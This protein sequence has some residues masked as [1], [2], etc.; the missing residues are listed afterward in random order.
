MALPTG[1]NSFVLTFGV[2]GV[3][4]ADENLG[5]RV[6]VKAATNAIWGSTGQPYLNKEQT[7]TAAVGQTGSITLIN[8]DQDGFVDGNGNGLRNWTY[9]IHVDYI[10][11]TGKVVSSSNKNLAYMTAMGSPIDLDLTIPVST[12]AG[13]I[14]DIPDGSFAL[15]AGGVDGQ[16]LGLVNGQLGWI[17]LGTGSGSNTLTATGQPNITGTAQPGN[18]LTATTGSWSPAPTSYGYQWKR[19]GNTILGATT[20]TYTVATADIG[21][22]LTVTV[23]ATRT[24]YT[25]G[26]ATSAPTTVTAVGTGGGS[27][28]GSPIVTETGDSLTTESGDL[29][30][31]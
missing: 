10:D 3:L 25:T 21:Q 2:A 29:L 6:T 1:M 15:P 27:T 9:A 20:A 19:A 17:T 16:V 23:V 24:G 8:P 26:T 31:A 4:G 30:A 28:A 13:V 12:S 18:V 14:V 5:M 11:Y 7:A 22:A